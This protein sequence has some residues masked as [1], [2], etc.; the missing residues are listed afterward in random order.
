MVQSCPPGLSFN[1][2]KDECDWPHVGECF[3]SRGLAVRQPVRQKKINLVLSINLICHFSHALE[4]K[5]EHLQRTLKTAA[6]PSSFAI[7]MLQLNSVVKTECSLMLR[8][9]FAIGHRMY[10]AELVML[11][12]RNVM[13]RLKNQRSFL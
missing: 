10:D 3:D 2:L 6:N 5:Q 13:L 1:S 8:K 7:I 12:V 11:I 4:P 9:M